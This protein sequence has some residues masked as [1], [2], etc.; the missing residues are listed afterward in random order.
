MI[1]YCCYARSG[2]TAFPLYMLT[3]SSFLSTFDLIADPNI[4]VQLMHCYVP[5]F[6]TRVS[7]H[8]GLHV[9]VK[10]SITSE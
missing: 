3:N 9:Y 7:T 8:R 2:R 5:S 4:V 10:D 1:N 6:H